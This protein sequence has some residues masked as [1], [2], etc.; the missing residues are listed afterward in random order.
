[1]EVWSSFSYPLLSI[2]FSIFYIN[3]PMS[4]SSYH[5]TFSLFPVP[6]FFIHIPYPIIPY[7]LSLTLYPFYLMHY[8]LFLFI[9]PSPLPLILY[10]FSYPL[11]L[12]PPLLSFIS[13]Y[14]KS[15]KFQFLKNFNPTFHKFLILFLFQ[16]LENCIT[17]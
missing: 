10:P 4:L 2:P 8:L 14:L 6:Y 1:M 13:P 17:V 12:I 15:S 7:P 16:A 9:I 11:S 3:F 5:I